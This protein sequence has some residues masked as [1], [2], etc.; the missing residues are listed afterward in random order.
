MPRRKESFEVGEHYHIFNRGVDRQ[1]VYFS[2]ENYLFFLRRMG[3]YLCCI[4]PPE[5]N[6]SSPETRSCQILAYCLMPDHYHLLVQICANTFSASMQSLS[7]SYTNAINRDRKRVGPLFQGR[8]CAKPIDEELGLLHVS[9]YIHRNPVDAGL[10]K[11]PHAW[12]FS[13]Y[14]DYTDVRHG[15]LPNLSSVLTIAGG[16]E[17]YRRFVEDQ[18]RHPPVSIEN[19]LFKE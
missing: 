2:R 12:E 11:L 9:R 1:P 18:E 6:G 5:W 19:Y 15:R 17:R 3:Q 13:S 7:Q 8:F 4:N 16:R 14:L 10:V